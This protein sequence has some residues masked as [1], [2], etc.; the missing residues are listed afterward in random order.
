MFFRELLENR[1]PTGIKHIVFNDDHRQQTMEAA[2][3]HGEGPTKV[4]FGAE[5]YAVFE[6][7]RRIAKPWLLL[8]VYHFTILQ[9]AAFLKILEGAEKY[10]ER[11][12]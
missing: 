8:L 12:H 2:D 5:I 9:V 4:Q 3:G 11:R 6:S 10:A 7:T 1:T